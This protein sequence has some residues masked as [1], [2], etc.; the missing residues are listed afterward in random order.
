[1]FFDGSRY[2]RVAEY[3]L[4]DG[5]GNA[6]TLKRTREPRLLEAAHEY[7]VREGDR[8]DLLAMKFYRN[9]RKWWLIADANPQILS[10]EDLLVPG[11]LIFIP[12]DSALD[13]GPGR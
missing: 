5:Q 1:M 6:R 11:L 12:R 7:Q 2:L 9:P 13:A 3:S 4:L 8:L 10:P